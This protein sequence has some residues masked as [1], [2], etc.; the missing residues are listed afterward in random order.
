[1]GW[2]VLLSALAARSGLLEGWPH[3][4]SSFPSA[5]AGDPPWRRCSK[6]RRK[7]AGDDTGA[8]EAF[9]YPVSTRIQRSRAARRPSQV[10]Q[11]PQSGERQ[12]PRPRSRLSAASVSPPVIDD[13]FLP[14]SP[15][16]EKRAD[17]SHERQKGWRPWRALKRLGL[18]IYRQ[19][20]ILLGLMFFLA[21]F[22][23]TIIRD[24]KDVL[25]ISCPGGPEIIPF[26]STY[27]NL[28]LS[29]VFMQLYW[30]ISTFLGAETLFYSVF[31]PFLAFFV[32]FAYFV[33]PNLNKIHPTWLIPFIEEKLPWAYRYE[34]LLQVIQNWSVSLYYL[35]AEL[36]GSVTISLLFWGFC[37]EVS[38]VKESQD[39]YP[40]Y[41]VGGQIALIISGII[42]SRMATMPAS[43]PPG[44]DCFSLSLRRLMNTLGGCGLAFAGIFWFMNRFFINNPKIYP[45]GDIVTPSN[46][47]GPTPTPTGE[48]DKTAPVKE[49]KRNNRKTKLGVRATFRL[50][51]SSSYIQNLAMMLV[52]FGASLNIVEVVWKILLREY[53]TDRNALTNFYG[54]YSTLSGVATMGLMLLNRWIVKKRGFRTSALITPVVLSSTGLLFFLC[55]LGRGGWGGPL[56]PLLSTIPLD[57][58]VWVG[59]IQNIFSKS[60]RYA[61]LDQCKEWAYLPLGQELKSKGKAA[62]DLVGIPFG[63]SVASLVQ[64]FIIVQ[65]GHLLPATPWLALTLT[66]T[67]AVWLKST[68]QLS[69]QYHNM[70]ECGEEECDG[71]D[72]AKGVTPLIAATG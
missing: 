23:S 13:A 29:A 38:S 33:F 71:Q 20:Q 60:A 52:C 17:E 47:K 66:I 27:V 62:I 3:A 54:V 16:E 25:V 1:M 14:A 56:T 59:A 5:Q 57:F 69:R 41:G 32:G 64:Q 37:N 65:M 39:I 45:P 44:V 67:T 68:V 36:W 30:K 35:I 70:L 72:G 40:L 50:L 34:S 9:L 58:L 15:P 51:A 28:P 8:S 26:L 2:H 43:C 6:W 7:A 63:E 24:T 10:R 46:A 61:L 18:P 42:I 11:Q 4:L 22:N 55:L 53:Y 19:K 48:A 31:F 21:L 49:E 12:R